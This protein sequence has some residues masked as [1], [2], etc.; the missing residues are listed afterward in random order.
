[1]N[2]KRILRAFSCCIGTFSLTLGG[3]LRLLFL[4]CLPPLLRLLQNSFLLDGTQAVLVCLGWLN[5]LLVP[6][7]SLNNARASQLSEFGSVVL[8]KGPILDISGLALVK[9][10]PIAFAFFSIEMGGVGQDCNAV[11]SLPPCQ[12]Y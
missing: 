11:P 1:M 8:R 10:H 2:F 12:P 7:S 9:D 6:S 3:K 5:G 4:L